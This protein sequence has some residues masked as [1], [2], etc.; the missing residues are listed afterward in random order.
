[1]KCNDLNKLGGALSEGQA[2]IL[3]T[4]TVY[5][6]FA[7]ALHPQS[8]EHVYELKG[9]PKYKALNLNVAD[10]STI[11]HYSENQPLYLKELYESFLPGP[12]TI[13]LKANHLVPEWINAGLDSIGFRVPNHPVT[14]Q[15]IKEYGPLVGP[16]ANKSGQ[17]SGT[18]FYEIETELGTEL[19]GWSDDASISGFDSTILDLTGPRARILRQGQISKEELESKIPGLVIEEGEDQL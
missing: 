1:M 15:L 18:I 2:L 7:Q 10:L 19:M 5:G 12:L 13:I 16:S 3:P 4:E 14:L 17:Q 6:I 8:V 11:I 9:R